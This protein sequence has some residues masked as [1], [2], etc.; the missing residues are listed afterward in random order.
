[1]LDDHAGR[2]RK[3]ADALERGIC[4]GKVVERK[5]L[6]LQLR[7][8]AEGRA[9]RVGGDVERRLLVRVLAVAQIETLAE[10]QREQIGELS[11][12][13]PGGAGEERA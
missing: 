10:L 7:S 3:L 2:R 6:A 12:R 11:G 9:L 1:V 4:I 13:G 5:L 8:R